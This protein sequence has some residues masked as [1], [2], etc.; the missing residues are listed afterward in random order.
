MKYLSN[1]KCTDDYKAIRSEKSKLIGFPDVMNV[2]EIFQ[3]EF[4]GRIL[5][6]T[7]INEPVIRVKCCCK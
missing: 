2:I 6:Q 1:D 5:F 4:G 7:P 3:C